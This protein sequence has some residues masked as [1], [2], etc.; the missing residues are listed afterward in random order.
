MLTLSTRRYASR[1]AASTDIARPARGQTR[2]TLVRVAADLLEEGGIE[3]V[4]LR[5][6][7][8][9]AGVSRAAP[10][11]HFDSKEGLLAA[12]CAHDLVV[13]REALEEAA[14]RARTPLGALE[15]MLDVFIASARLQPH[16]YGLLFSSEFEGR[17]DPELEEAAEACLAV[18]IAATAA[19]LPPGDPRRRDP[20][21]TAALIIATAHG[22]ADLERNGHLTREKWGTD[23]RSVLRQLIATIAD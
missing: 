6:V 22:V 1:V 20:R 2:D 19:V 15:R 8:R 14:A 7:G 10:Y 12:V 5:E 18:F 13:L 17:D 16:R 11:R 23:G 9:R 3:A 4:T 21:R